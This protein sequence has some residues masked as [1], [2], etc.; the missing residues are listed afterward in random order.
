MVKILIRKNDL[1]M[2]FLQDAKMLHK[3]MNPLIVWLVEKFFR[4]Q[5]L[6]SLDF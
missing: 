5:K 6:L 3:Y 4:T 2:P 1:N